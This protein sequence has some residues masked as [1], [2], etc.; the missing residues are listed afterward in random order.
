MFQ[1]N[2][3]SVLGLSGKNLSLLGMDL[4]KPKIF[5][6]FKINNKNGISNYLTG[7]AELEEIINHTSIPGLDVITSGPIRPIL[8][9]LLMSDNNMKFIER[10]KE[11]YEYVIIDSPVGLVADSFE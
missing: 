6:D 5:G 2:I 10:L 11:I 4:R 9:E 7:Q 8:R 1:L 3:A